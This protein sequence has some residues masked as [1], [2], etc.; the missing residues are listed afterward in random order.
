[1][2]K[3]Y[4]LTKSNSPASIPSLTDLMA[5]IRKIKGVKQA[6]AL[7]GPHGGIAYV[8]VEDYEQLM[9][10]QV[11]LYELEGIDS[12]DTRIAWPR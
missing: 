8:E 2:I 9:E 7:I 3:A 11:E 4:I 12:A 6:H 5:E 1:M 10:T